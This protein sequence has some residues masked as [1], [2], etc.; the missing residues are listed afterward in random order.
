[1]ANS[2][3]SCARSWVKSI[4]WRVIGIFILGGLSWLFTRSWEQTTLITVTFH[5]IRLVL[6][7]F[8]ERYWE[9]I[10]WGRRRVGEDY[11]I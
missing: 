2:V 7:Y 5:S 10:H 11:M 6:Y 8:H 4:T 3:D 1:M 9:K